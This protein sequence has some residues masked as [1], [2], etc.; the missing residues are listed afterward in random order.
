ME[1]GLALDGLTSGIHGTFKRE[2]GPGVGDD[3]GRGHKEF[4][5]SIEAG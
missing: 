1:L 3:T 5:M 4:L 2:F